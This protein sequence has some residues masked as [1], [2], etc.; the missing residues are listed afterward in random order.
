MIGTITS[1]SIRAAAPPGLV[2]RISARAEHLLAGAFAAW[3]SISVQ[4]LLGPGRA[5]GPAAA[6]FVVGT[7]GLAT[8]VLTAVVALL[9]FIPIGASVPRPSARTLLFACAASAATGALSVFVASV[10]AEA[11]VPLG[12]D[13]RDAVVRMTATAMRIFAAAIVFAA[14]IAGM[15]RK[16]SAFA[17]WPFGVALVAFRAA[18]AGDFSLA[19]AGRA[20][21]YDLACLVLL[22]VGFSSLGRLATL[23][24]VRT[25]ARAGFALLVA[26]CLATLALVGT[27]AG[28]RSAF[29]ESFPGPA[30][31]LG[32]IRGFFDFDGDG[33]P[34]VL[35]GTDCDD[36]DETVGPAAIEII[37]NGRDDNC[38]G[39]DLPTAAPDPPDPLPTATSGTSVILV[40][41][42][43]WRAETL[44]ARTD[45]G[46]PL[47]PNLKSFAR[48]AAVFS[49][50]YAQAPYTDLS[51]RSF[52]T[53]RYPMDFDDGTHFF[54]QEPSL[55]EV[56]KGAGYVTSCLQQVWLLSPY[57]LLGFD[58]I[59]TELAAENADFN[60][61]TSHKMTAK[62]LRELAA[63]EARGRPFFLWIHYFDPHSTHVL[64]SGAPVV[65]TSE[66]SRYLQE[67]WFTDHSLGPLLAAIA[68]SR[69][70]ERGYV[71]IAGDHGELIGEKGR[72]GH[73]LWMDEEVLR[74]PLLVRGPG[75][76]SGTFGT[77]IRLVDMYPTILALAAGARAATDGRD[78]SDVWSG[79]DTRDRDVFAMTSYRGSR[80]RAAIS[81]SW[82]LVENVA[83]GATWLFRIDASGREG[84]NLIDDHP[85]DARRM[86]DLLGR[87]WD[88]SM[89]DA[90]VRRKLR[91]L[92]RRMLPDAITKVWER[93]VSRLEC[94]R[95]DDAACRRI[96]AA[97]RG[98]R[99][100]NLDN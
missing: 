41:I 39:G 9:V 31:I 58:R 88:L 64:I 38:I 11:L 1:P 70:T 75:V 57:A 73:A 97:A 77:R 28:A 99:G 89:N 48:S 46:D 63:L 66:R 35:G 2:S 50:A 29:E 26:C 51:M 36:W 60:G 24:H 47:M 25:V 34:G 40:T 62:A 65:G 21:H 43:A 5:A 84:D 95:G 17:L 74:V 68:G 82:K 27:R 14:V 59:D 22:L 20:A 42:D 81:G 3:L 90:V 93:D 67:I 78:L 23:P 7:L 100:S 94:Q 55:A 79:R 16:A 33:F 86:R 92:P 15:E 96:E 13:V 83:S 52:L 18:A 12:L 76:P 71:V 44:A 87:R 8:C 10:L 72:V 91:L 56:L 98:D 69:F 37:G 49:R 61:I 80:L 53:G 30:G 4:T 85:A 6:L 19:L 32:L 54:G 45:E